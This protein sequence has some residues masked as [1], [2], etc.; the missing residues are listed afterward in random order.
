MDSETQMDVVRAEALT[1]PEQARA[2]AIVDAPSYNGAAGLLKA[3][4]ALRAKIAETFQPH[5]KRAHE[6]HTALVKEQ[7][8]AEAPLTE[9]ELIIKRGLVTYDQEQER[10]R[11]IEQRRLEDIARKSEEARRLEEAAAMEKEAAATGDTALRAEAEALIAEPVYVAPIQVEKA[12]PAVKGISYRTTYSA[13]V[14]NKRL[15]IQFVADNP[16][17]ENLLDANMVA[18]NGQA[19]SLKLAMQIPGVVV[20]EKRDI[21]AGS[22]R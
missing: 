13:R 12:T 1:W 2:L 5:V 4:K 19:R 9:A 22:G 14:T 6:A 11:Q 20:D 21:A 17:F 8:D 15:L 18:L 16:Q 10:L 7:A 3:I